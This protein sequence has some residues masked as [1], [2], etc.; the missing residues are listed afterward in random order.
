MNASSQK[1]TWRCGGCGAE[2]VEFV[3]TAPDSC[4][5]CKRTIVD[6]GQLIEMAQD[7]GL[8]VPAP[9]ETRGMRFKRCPNCGGN[10]LREEHSCSD[11]GAAL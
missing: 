1:W 7:T 8:V 5:K 4:S 9:L 2:H 3:G 6:L 11:C 10:C